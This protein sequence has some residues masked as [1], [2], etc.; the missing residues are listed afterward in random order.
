MEFNESVIRQ[1]YRFDPTLFALDGPEDF[2]LPSGGKSSL[3]MKNEVPLVL[4]LLDFVAVRLPFWWLL[5]WT[6]DLT[7]EG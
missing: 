7:T 5:C 1:N 4:P 2:E 6:S 3:L